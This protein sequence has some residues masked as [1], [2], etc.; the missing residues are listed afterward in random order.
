MCH[1]WKIPQGP[2]QSVT[3]INIIGE[4][5]SRQV[6][7]INLNIIRGLNDDTQ[8]ICKPACCTLFLILP[9]VQASLRDYQVTKI[10]LAERKGSTSAQQQYQHTVDSSHTS[11]D[12]FTSK[13]GGYTLINLGVHKYGEPAHRKILWENFTHRGTKKTS[14]PRR[15]ETE[16]LDKGREKSRAPG[17]KGEEGPRGK[18]R[19]GAKETAGHSLLEYWPQ[20]SFSETA[21]WSKLPLSIPYMLYVI[22]VDVPRKP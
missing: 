7:R 8:Y 20:R 2:D 1:L 19:R 22:N 4:G 13:N 14:T 6:N 18:R 3:S 21:H 15:K 17:K 11:A 5:N 16:H 10:I 9:I 12:I